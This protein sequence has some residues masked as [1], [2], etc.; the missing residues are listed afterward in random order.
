VRYP[1]GG[2]QSDLAV[3]DLQGDGAEDLVTANTRGQAIS[4]LLNRRQGLFQTP[5]LWGASPPTSLTLARLDAN[6]SLDVLFASGAGST[7]GVYRGQ[8]N[9]T[10]DS[11]VSAPSGSGLRGVAVW[12]SNGSRRA[13]VLNA[14][15]QVVSVFPVNGDG[16]LGTK[17]DYSAPT[18]LHSL[19]VADFNGDGRSDLAVSHS[20]AC[21]SAENTACQ[22]V[23]VL[24]GKSDDT[25]EAQRITSTGGTPLGLVAARL[26][27]DVLMDLVVADSSRH[28]VLVLSGRGDGSFFV[29]ASYPTVRSPSRLALV[30]INRDS[31]PDLVVGGLGSELSVLL[32]QPGGTFA[33]QVPLTAS[34]QESGIRALAAADFDKDGSNDLAVLTGTGVQLLW[35]V[36]R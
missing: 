20:D 13:A 15:S 25:F 19:V 34:T 21:T 33:A 36:C 4:V 3:G 2:E 35:G 1:L 24:L 29:Q 6:A 9:G 18:G 10:F 22:S 26:D 32:G 8:G 11:L 14:D 17:V 12:E 7:L 31:L 27:T 23:S 30:D 28:Q 5:S 16:S